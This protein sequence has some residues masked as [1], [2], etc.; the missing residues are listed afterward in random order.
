[1]VFF[2]SIVILGLALAP[3]L[4]VKAQLVTPGVRPGMSFTY[5]T[6]DGSPWVWMYPSAAPPLMQWEP[7]VNM[8]TIAFNV[9]SNWNLNAP[10]SQIMFNET[11][12]YGN[13][14][15]VRWPGQTVDVNTGMGIGAS[16]FIAP[17]LGNGNH[18]YPG[19]GTSQTIN[20]T[21][22]DHT[23][24]PGRKVCVLNRTIA[25]PLQ[26]KSSEMAAERVVFIWDWS[27]GVLLGAFEEASSYNPTTGVGVQGAIL[28]ELIA[29]N[30][31]I[32][33]QYPKPTDMTPIYIVVAVGIIIILGVVIVRIVTRGPKKRHKRLKE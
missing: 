26:N 5:G 13:G 21:R 24:W 2:L 12:T 27:T 7:F 23:Y 22:V 9:T 15:I 19:N 6:P 10:Y 8:R 32:P 29:N 18:I 28:Y 17:N 25:V 14:T 33:M 1:M 30:V 16:W 3:S 20:E 31:G 4:T 11:F